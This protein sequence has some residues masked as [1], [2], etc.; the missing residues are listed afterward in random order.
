MEISFF[1][2]L[3]FFFQKQILL[4]QDKPG[5]YVHYCMKYFTTFMLLSRECEGVSAQDKSKLGQEVSPTL[6]PNHQTERIIQNAR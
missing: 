2:L 1:H 6:Q 4:S 5:I 3:S